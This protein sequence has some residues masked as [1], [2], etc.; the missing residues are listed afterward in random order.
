[1]RGAKTSTSRRP[2]GG[3]TEVAA[4]ETTRAALIRHI[5]S[6]A[7]TVPQGSVGEYPFSSLAGAVGILGGSPGAPVDKQ[8]ELARR[9]T[10]MARDFD[11]YVVSQEQIQ[12]QRLIVLTAWQLMQALERSGR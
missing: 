9:L 12:A 8:I 6:C 4:I 5:E 7:A 1:M 11:G 3:T 2:P 10:Q